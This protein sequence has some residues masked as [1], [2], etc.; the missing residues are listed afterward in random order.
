MGTKSAGYVGVFALVAMFLLLGAG[1]AGTETLRVSIAVDPG[2]ASEVP[3]APGLRYGLQRLFNGQFGSM[4]TLDAE[5]MSETATG[6]GAA[7]AS[8]P[9]S[10]PAA[11]PAPDVSARVLLGLAGG[12]VTVSTDLTRARA[13]RSLVS[14]V[15][16][17]SPASLLSTM[18]GDLAFLFFSARGFSSLPLSPPPALAASLSTDSL[19]SLTG[20]NPED[21]EPIGLAAFGDEVTLCFPHRYLTLGPQLRISPSTIRDMDG[22]A[23]GREPLQ[24]SGVIA[25]DGDRLFLLSERSGRIAV[26]NPRLGSRQVIDAP[27]L[28]GLA[29]RLL[30]GETVAALTGSAGGPGVRLYSAGGGPARTLDVGASYVPAFDRDSEGNLWA[31][32]AGERRVRVLTREGREVFS[33]KPLFSAATMQLPQ[34]LAV[35]D[36]GSFLLGGSAEVWKFQGSGIPVWRLT[37]IPGRPA[38]SL[39]SSFDLGINRAT[40][41][42]TILDSPSRRLLSF[43]PAPPGAAAQGAAA[44]GAAAG[45]AVL[46]EKAA[47]WTAFA[48][49]LARDLV[50]DRADAAFLRAAETLRGLTAESPEDENAAGLL[51]YVLSRRR[52]VRSALAGSRDVQ[53]VTARL[54]VEPARDCRVSVFLEA[55][56]RNRQGQAL[57]GVRVHVSVPALGF[58]PALAALETL[59]AGQEQTVR[60]PLG[61]SDAE[62]APGTKIVQAFALVTGDRGQD[63]VTAALTFPA[64]IALSGEPGDSGSAL[65]CRAVSP[66]TLAASLGSS[67]LSGTVPDPPQPLADLAAILDA[68][69]A[70]RR[71]APAGQQSGGTGMRAALRGLSPDEGDWTVVTAS[72]SSSLGLP[73]AVLFVGDRPL[74]LVD[75]RVPFFTA[76]SAVPELK[77]FR[78]SLARISP[79][80]TLWIPL[81]GRVRPPGREMAANMPPGATVA[82]SFADALQLLSSH[83]TAAAV[84][85]ELSASSYRKNTPSPFPLVLPAITA[86]PSLEALRGLVGA[87]AAGL[88]SP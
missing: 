25:A 51:Q 17:G 87:A 72:I 74:A 84:R 77:R 16:I 71:P 31:W 29:A 81:S 38:E 50:F 18:A 86:R 8:G 61:L 21:L 23:V 32:D 12:V 3:G 53:V 66:D 40:G 35:F 39:P 65:A 36:D 10:A 67:L 68:L 4:V 76:L 7:P 63:S 34:Q 15:P 85:S 80:G 20:W 24:L 58:T 64:P 45:G 46:A 88:P 28:S 41:S 54:V 48:D 60:V 44:G 75:T 57:T 83:D 43:A 26:V 59:P 49:G 14:T 11:A 78:E 79:A 19:R 70:A 2:A 56:L 33:I 6:A 73:A 37:R 13:T 5:A 62:I 82:W 9:A 42:L 27:G 47:G 52:E 69:G 55:A 22:Q 30:E 1:N